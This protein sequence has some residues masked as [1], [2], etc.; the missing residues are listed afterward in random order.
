MKVFMSLL[1]AVGLAGSAL[2]HAAD[3]AA[4]G[5]AST[6]TKPASALPAGVTE[7]MMAPPPVPAFMLEKPGK[8]ISMEEMVRQ[9]RDAEK[10]SGKQGNRTASPAPAE[11]GKPAAGTG[12]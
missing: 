8:A 4:P 2:V 9:A 3:T 1:V 11:Q 12:K 7:D 5:T 6:S 10:K